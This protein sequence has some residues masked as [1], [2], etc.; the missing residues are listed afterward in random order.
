[1]IT[2]NIVSKILERKRVIN[3]LHIGKTGGT[4]FLIFFQEA[5][6][7]NRLFW[8]YRIVY[9]DHDSVSS[10][11]LSGE[12]CFF[13]IRHPMKRF[14][15]AFWY[16]KRISHTYWGKKNNMEDSKHLQY[17]DNPTTLLKALQNKNASLHQEAKTAM[18]EVDHFRRDYQ[19]YFSDAMNYINQWNVKFI[20]E[21]E[22]YEASILRLA[23]IIGFSK[24]SIN[25]EKKNASHTDHG[26]HG[27]L[28]G[29]KIFE[30]MFP[31]E[32]KIYNRLKNLK[33][34]LDE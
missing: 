22:C 30:D 7:I 26:V 29:K 2:N 33:R 8:N 14:A 19:F 12:L 24:A 32:M 20:G 16:Q 5:N 28:D 10:K 25:I 23:E 31:E 1:M 18:L 6:V 9:V 34:Q 21:Q 15:S 3:F 4:S 13:F 11:L 27:N 17:F